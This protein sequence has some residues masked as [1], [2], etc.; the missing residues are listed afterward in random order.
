MKSHLKTYL[1]TVTTVF[2]FQYHI[3]CNA[4]SLSAALKK[5]TTIHSEKTIPEKEI[6]ELA[7]AI[8]LIQQNYIK[9]VS[10]KTLFNNAINGMVTKLDPHSA[11]LDKSQLKTLQ[12][13]V[14]GEFVGIGVELTTEHGLLRVISPINDSPAAKAG[15]KSGDLI[16]K[17]DNKLIQDMSINEAIDNIKG[18]AGTPVTLT[19]IRK[20][21][22]KPI[23]ITMM[24]EAIKIKAVESKILA[25]GYGY[26]RLSL[27]QGPVAK[28]VQNAIEKLKIESQ[29]QLK[30]LVLDLRNNPGGLL[31]VSADVVDL[32]LDKKETQRYHNLIVYTKGRISNSDVKFYAH[33]NDQIP[34]VPVVIL[35]NGGTA[36][37]AEIVAGAMQD[38][39]R[40]IIM[41]TRSFGKGSVQTV[42]PINDD[43]ALKLTTALYYTPAG[44]EI[45]A[46]GI[47]PDVIVPELTVN[48]KQM[49]SSLDIDEA[50]Y[51]GHIENHDKNNESEKL[52]LLQ[53]KNQQKSA[54]E[55]AKKDYQLYEA[56]MMLK[57]M[58][59]IR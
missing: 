52:L 17:V 5:N 50:N 35:I 7:T 49:S 42:L 23:N 10:Q 44:R 28:Q 6:G 20:N 31:D 43:S 34:H 48:E 2:L 25:P 57:G 4:F 54:I 9:Q 58:H 36:S 45:Q 15:L 19:I 18:K 53:H 55:L 3:T 56:W 11:F 12:T 38:Y 32:F 16:L 30:G 29:G 21:E 40:A 47:E 27:F 24:R 22:D 41:G 26:V 39:K 1:I 8:Y 33:D 59:A 51:D 37:A 14:T 46:R 13:T